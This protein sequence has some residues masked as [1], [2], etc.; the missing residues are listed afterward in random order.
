MESVENFYRVASMGEVNSGK[1]T[2]MGSLVKYCSQRSI[3]VSQLC[4]LT[5]SLMHERENSITWSVGHQYCDFQGVRIHFLDDPGHFERFGVTLSG[6]KDADLIIYTICA[7]D[8]NFD[9]FRFHLRI[10]EWL[11]KQNVFCVLNKVNE[12]INEKDLR[13]KID[14]E[15]K[16]MGF[17]EVMISSI[18]KQ[19]TQ[20]RSPDENLKNI[21]C[22]SD[23]L[24]SQLK[25]LKNNK[26]L[27]K[28][29]E[30]PSILFWERPKSPHLLAV[31]KDGLQLR[32]T[33]IENLIWK[34]SKTQYRHESV[35]LADLNVGLPK[36][37]KDSKSSILGVAEPESFR[38]VGILKK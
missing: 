28:L 9:L 34:G 3:V 31:W 12:S 18:V 11:G 10:L 7:S 5:D 29:K 36:I 24:M 2:I 32:F 16:K 38:V 15:F 21:E 33:P 22:L 23:Q 6:I 13:E 17:N 4:D 1:S 14:Q 20:F 8:F 25:S 26:P 37:I 30:E 35:E 19:Q 27:E